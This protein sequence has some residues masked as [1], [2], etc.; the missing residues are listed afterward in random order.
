M[1]QMR[2]EHKILIRK[3]EG[4]R[5]IVKTR[6]IWEDITKITLKELQVRAWTGFNWLAQY[7][8][9]CQSLVNMVIIF[10]FHK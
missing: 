9:H 6:C 4:K 10:R 1:G 3:P 8:V 2:Y 5:Q 7:R